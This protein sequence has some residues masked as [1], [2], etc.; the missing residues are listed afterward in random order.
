[1]NT[2]GFFLDKSYGFLLL[3]VQKCSFFNHQRLNRVLCKKTAGKIFCYK[4][5]KI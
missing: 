3:M 4:N 1:M 2:S 5:V